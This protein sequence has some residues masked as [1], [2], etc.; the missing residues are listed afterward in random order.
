MA[1]LL[2][3]KVGVPEYVLSRSTRTWGSC[4]SGQGPPRVPAALPSARGRARPT[5]GSGFVSGNRDRSRTSRPNSMRTRSTGSSITITTMAPP[6]SEVITG[7]LLLL[8]RLL[9]MG[10]TCPP[11]TEQLGRPS[12]GGA[13]RRGRE[14]L[15]GDVR[16]GYTRRPGRTRH[17][18]RRLADERH[19]L[20]GRGEADTAGIQRV[21]FSAGPPPHAHPPSWP[22]W[23]RVRQCIR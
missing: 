17:G 18:N 20:T 12:E 8:P 16:T 23:P 7:Q 11:S 13:A 15:Q 5:R 14:L 10:D 22:A 3:I 9:R 4:S 6:G 1:R 19:V 2:L 21:G